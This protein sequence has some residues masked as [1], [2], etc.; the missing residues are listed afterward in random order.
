[1]GSNDEVCQNTARSWITLLAA[2]FCVGLKGSSCQSPYLLGYLP[3]NGNSGVLKKEP[4]N[5]PLRP[6]AAINS[7]N[8]GAAATNVP[9]LNAVSRAFSAA[10]LNVGSLS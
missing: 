1:M 6:G 3:I 8:T 9:R 10:E 4:T 2:P 5:A 7:A